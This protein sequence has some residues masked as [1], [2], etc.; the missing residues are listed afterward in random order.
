MLVHC[1]HNIEQNK[2]ISGSSSTKFFKQEQDSDPAQDL[3]QHANHM[4][5]TKP[6]IF[7]LIYMQ[8]A[9]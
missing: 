1:T 6:I 5:T 8:I 9:T 4:V 7:T 3:N 2:K